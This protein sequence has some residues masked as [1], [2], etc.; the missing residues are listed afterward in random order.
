MVSVVAALSVL[1]SSCPSDAAARAK[2]LYQQLDYPK[3][4]EAVAKVEACVDGTAEELAEAFR[5][6][7]QSA[8]ALSEPKA[9][10]AAFALVATVAP[11]YAL[12]PAVAPKVRALFTQART[13]ATRGLQVFVR[14]VGRSREGVELQLFDPQQKATAVRVLWAEGEA[15][16]TR[17]EGDRWRAVLPRGLSRATLKVEQRDALVYTAVEQEL[18]EAARLPPSATLLPQLTPVEPAIPMQAPPPAPAAAG[19]PRWAIFAGAGA[20]AALVTGLVVGLV[21]ARNARFDGSLG[22]LELTPPK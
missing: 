1:I 5:W 8:A 19:V 3:A 9:A 18:P 21:V 2:G 10:V 6:R 14:A 7:A 4:I 12:D 15:T 22:R 17:A 11:G 13:Q 20:G 16:A